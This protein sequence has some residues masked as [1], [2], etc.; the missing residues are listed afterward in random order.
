MAPVMIFSLPVFI[1][2]KILQPENRIPVGLQVSLNLMADAR[3]H[4]IGA[5]ENQD[6]HRL[7]ARL[8]IDDAAA[9]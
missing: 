4:M 6:G 9:L 2:G 7:L 8:K 1:A 5:G 3:I